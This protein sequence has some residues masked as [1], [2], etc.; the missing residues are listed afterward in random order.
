[1]FFSSSCSSSP[2]I[3]RGL[4]HCLVGFVSGWLLSLRHLHNHKLLSHRAEAAVVPLKFL[5]VRCHPLFV[6]GV[7]EYESDEDWGYTGRLFCG[8][9]VALQHTRIVLYIAGVSLEEKMR[10]MTGCEREA[11]NSE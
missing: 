1:M 9:R 10:T 11:V 3:L 4:S 7:G 6:W 8:T 2:L 5:I